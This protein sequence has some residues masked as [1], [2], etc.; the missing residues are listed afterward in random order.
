MYCNCI[1]VTLGFNNLRIWAVVSKEN[2][3]GIYMKNITS[4][5]V[6]RETTE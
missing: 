6:E 2:F 3:K 5:L 1:N 4:K